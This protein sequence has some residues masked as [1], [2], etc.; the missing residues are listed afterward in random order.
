MNGLKTRILIIALLFSFF[1]VKAENVK[2]WYL[3]P[4]NDWMEALPIGNGRMGAMVFGNPV[5]ERI[6]LNEDSLWPGGPEWADNNKGTPE[7]LEKIRELMREGKFAE[8]DGLIVASFS[9]KESNFSHQ[10]MGD[11]FINFE[12]HDH[13]TDYKRWLSLDSAV[14]TS[15]YKVDGNTITQQVFS[16]NPDNVL[17]VHLKSDVSGGI[18]CEIGLSRPED[19]GHPTVI[20]SSVEN[21]LKMD[22]M[23]TQYGGMLDSKP[24]P[25]DNGVKFQGLLKAKNSGGKVV[26]KEGILKLENV[27]EATLY[28]FSNTSFYHDNF[29]AVNEQQWVSTRDKSYQQLLDAHVKDFK[30]IFDRVELNL[31]VENSDSLPIDKRLQNLTAENSDPALEALLFQYGRYLLISSSRPGTNPANLQGLWNKDISAPWNADYHIN[32]NLQMNYWPAEVCNLSE[33]HDPLFDFIDRLIV[34]GKKTAREQYGCR[35]AVVHHTTDLWAT[36]WMRAAT[37]Y[38][39]AWTGGGG[40]IVQ[41]L[42]TRYQFTQNKEFLRERVYPVTKE[43]ALFYADWLKKS[44]IDGKLISYPSTSPENSFVGPDGNNAAS[45]LGS[46]MDQQIIAEV[47]SN[48]LKTAAILGIDDDFT[49]EIKDK[50]GSLRSGLE[51]GPDGRVLEWDRPYEELEK[52]HRHMSHLYALYPSNM[53]DLDETPSLAEAAQK[54]I[55][56]RLA[57]G[58]AGTGWSR[59][60]LINFSARLRDHKMT[61]E[62]IGLFLKNSVAKN[63][64]CLHPPF[65]IDGNFGYT[66]GVAE[67]LIQSH[68]QDEKGNFIVH[69]LPSLPSGWE[70]GS[71]KG[72]RARGGFAVDMTWDNGILESACVYSDKG[73]TCKVRLQDKT[74][75]LELK[76]GEKRELKGITGM[77]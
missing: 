31:S 58:G 62:H 16:S 54:T 33:M 27:T 12:G 74:I 4:A 53:I 13:Y 51:I 44:P 52:G 6:Q 42:W 50:L 9:R 66:A 64:F 70:T 39:G 21:G 17:I 15:Q 24:Y 22:G 71:V 75:E 11:M 29:E 5:K 73:G 34:N 7:D 37:A 49:N 72:L 36:T 68:K 8:A 67:M 32:I 25:V 56:Y 69:L 40:W 46:A 76:A 48:V 14:V 41:H 23:V 59:A 55:D 19:S 35:G 45:C 77:P 2:L 57:N 3:Q 20:V 38:W 63:L 18:N 61:G 10:T 26:S 60:W 43:I 30:S 65:Q 47:F 28:F 1:M